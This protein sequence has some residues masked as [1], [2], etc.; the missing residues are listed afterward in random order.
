MTPSSAHWLVDVNYE[1][2][3]EVV[4][5]AAAP[6]IVRPVIGIVTYEDMA[7]CLGWPEQ[8][9]G[10]ADIL[11]LRADPEGWA[12]YPCAKA[13]WGQRPLMAFTDPATS[14]TGRSLLLALYAIAAGKLPE[15]LTAADVTDP[16]VVRYVKEFQGLVDHYLIGTTVLNTKIHQGPRY[17]HFFIM[18]EDNLI[19]LYDGDGTRLH[20]RREGHP[21]TDRGADGHDLSQR[22]LDAS[23]QLRLHRA[24]T[25]GVRPAGRGSRGVAR[26][27]PRR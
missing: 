11:A 8:E 24:G 12:A 23:Q 20:R 3:H 15:D 27:P 2:G 6:S 21:S 5:L 1:L 25:L 26:L 14:S 9:L 13:E 17:G 18:P 22:G 19:H 10:F 7:R 16:K 4:D